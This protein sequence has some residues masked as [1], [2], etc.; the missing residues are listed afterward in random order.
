MAITFTFTIII[1][2]HLL[3]IAITTIKLLAHK[4]EM[5]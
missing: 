2:K 5:V 4:H 3:T 1:K